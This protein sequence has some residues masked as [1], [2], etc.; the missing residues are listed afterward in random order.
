M[1]LKSF[2]EI[3]DI[4]RNF[5]IVRKVSIHE[6]QVQ[7]LEIEHIPTHA[8]IMHV[9]ADDP[10]NSFCLSFQT[11]PNS[12]NGVAHILEHTV[13]CGSEKYPVRDPFFSMTRRSLNTYMNAL[14]GNDFTCYPAASQVEKDFY[15]LL[16]VYVDAVFHPKLLENS[17]KQEG[18]RLEFSDSNPNSLEFKGIV[19]NEMKGAMA[20]ANSRLVEKMNA[21]L[22]PDV[23]YG[24]NS[25]G[26]PSE[27]L[28]L[29]HE[30][31][32]E[33]HRTHYHPSRCLFYF[34]GN[35]PVQKH[36][37]YLAN[38]LLENVVAMAPL[39]P[40]ATQP[41]FKETKK[42]RCYY[43]ANPQETPEENSIVCVGWLT[44]HIQEQEDLLD[45]C[46]IDSCLMDTDAS[47]LKRALL[48]SK[49]CKQVS[50]SI[51]IDNAEVPIL[52]TFKGCSEQDSAKLETLLLDKLSEIAK[53][54]IDSKAIE[55][56]LHQLELSRSEITG[57]GFPFGLTL[58]SR[59]ALLKQHGAPPENGLMIHTLFEQVRTRLAS[60]P[61]YLE[62]IL[63][64]YFLQNP[65]RVTLTFVPDP[66]LADKEALDESAML[67]KIEGNLDSKTKQ[68]II[69]GAK[70]LEAYQKEIE[71]QDDDILP[72]LALE[73]IPRKSRG[74]KLDI[75]ADKSLQIFTH[76]CFTNQVTYLDYAVPLPDITEEELPYLRLLTSLYG[77]M[78]CGRK[79]FSEVLS[80]LHAYTGGVGAS[81]PIYYY[82]RNHNPSALQFCLRGRA[83]NR[84]LD[85]MCDI[86]REMTLGLDLSDKER[87]KEIINKQWSVLQST[88]IQGSM[89]YAS[90]LATSGISIATKVGY[91]WYGLGYYHFI[92]N[93]IHSLDTNLDLLIDKLKNLEERILH[94]N[95]ADI[96]VACDESA[97][98]KLSKHDYYGLHDIPQRPFFPW[99]GNIKV[100]SIPS[101]GKIVV[102]PV[103]FTSMVIPIVPYIDPSAPAVRLSAYLMDNVFLHQA[104]R[105]LGGAYGGGTSC[106]LMAGYFSFYGYRDP[107]I[108]S[109]LKAF[110]EAV[111]GLCDEEFSDDDLFEAKLEMIQGMD[112]P[113]APGSRTDV[114][115]TW[116][117][118]SK[119]YALRQQFREKTLNLTKEDIAKAAQNHFLPKLK[120]ATIVVFAG[121]ELL[122]NENHLIEKEG[123]SILLISEI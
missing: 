81:T 4:Y 71:E 36:L 57:D 109:T 110:E 106:N 59:A 46:L 39:P 115:Y 73:D 72:V 22:Y 3:G 55:S 102:S 42:E 68:A 27:I 65:H 89:R 116:W 58:F 78:G 28:T 24:Y 1:D 10:E 47:P 13:L 15:N 104:I 122:E 21:L 34:Y 16:D 111:Q 96:T 77:Q 5:K 18:H 105:E 99:K 86:I 44:C 32:C 41:R 83:L 121:K 84:N 114:E 31:L 117:K 123:K 119:P 85:K 43:P 49:L 90:N 45:L 53:T 92:K 38:T 8:Q 33:F 60:Q 108:S 88:L 9:I 11:Q 100:T 63:D 29:T 51:D 7:L 76:R 97:F 80:F 82:T 64:K 91:Y 56:A 118:E 6:L 94:G 2:Q 23:T 37:D 113:I 120:D 12:S 30:E 48:D 103:A 20:S 93:I 26:C 14:T 40:V 62:H 95:F 112:T 35:I 107:N 52:V 98:E 50:M 101:Q 66:A 54:G 25:G 70:S 69:E 75:F 19:Y 61:K 87:L 17:F 79:K 74:Y 67:R